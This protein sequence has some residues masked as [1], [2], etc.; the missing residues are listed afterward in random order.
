MSLAMMPSVFVFAMATGA[1]AVQKGLTLAEA[2]IMSVLVYA[3]SSQ[4]VALEVWPERF[5]SAGLLLVADVVAVVNSR[6]L[7]MSAALRPWIDH[8][9]P[10]INYSHLTVLTDANY[11]LA[12]RHRAEGGND[13]GVLIGSGV[14]LWVVWVVGTIPGH[15][16]GGIVGNPK[17]YG[18]DLV[19]PIYFAAIAVPL[20]RNH[21]DSRAWLVAAAAA[22][23]VHLTIPGHWHILAGALAGMAYAAFDPFSREAGDAS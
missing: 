6:L 19:M 8:L 7:L 12:A 9:P 17:T 5:T 13:A 11:I 15:H 2:T 18:L 22:L 23:L 21:R 4:M 20:W 14:A 1:T 10:A 16:L 3:G